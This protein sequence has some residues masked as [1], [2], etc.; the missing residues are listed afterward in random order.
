QLFTTQTHNK[1]RHSGPAAPATLTSSRACA[2]RYM[3]RRSLQ[4]RVVFVFFTLMVSVKSFAIMCGAPNSIDNVREGSSAFKVTFSGVTEVGTR[5][6]KMES[7]ERVWTRPYKLLH[8]NVAETLLGQSKT[9]IY[10]IYYLDKGLG[11]Y[12]A[13]PPEQLGAQY[14]LS[15]HTNEFASGSFEKPFI[16]GPCDL[17]KRI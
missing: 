6:F 8:F 12:K 4:L 5:D 7:R 11:S 15:F 13:N 3:H 1:P 9:E 10:V 2:G 16:N 14:F 17:Q